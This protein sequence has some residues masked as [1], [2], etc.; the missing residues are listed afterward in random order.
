MNNSKLLPNEELEEIK[1]RCERASPG[2][3]RSMVEGR[4]HTSGSDFIMTGTTEARGE[5]IELLGATIDDQEFIAHARQDIPRLL[6]EIERL[7]LE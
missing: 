6:E 5:D 2:P 4:D 7:R 1:Q 3:W